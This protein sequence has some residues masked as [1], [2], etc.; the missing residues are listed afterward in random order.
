MEHTKENMRQLRSLAAGI[1][2]LASAGLVIASINILNLMLARVLRRTREIG[3]SAALGASR[4]QIFRQSLAEALVL[5]IS[6]GALG[7]PLSF[8]LVK[9]MSGIMEGLDVSVGLTGVLA[10]ALSCIAASVIFG[11]Y[12]AYLGARVIPADALRGD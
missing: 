2:V 4:R 5:G 11:L 10:G 12:P 6:G 1:L 9:L 7:L 3:I 8:G